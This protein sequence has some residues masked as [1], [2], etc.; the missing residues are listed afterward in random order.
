MPGGDR[1]GPLGDGPMTGKRM[2]YCVSIENITFPIGYGRGMR[3]RNRFSGSRG[4]GFG[5]RGG[6]GFQQ[7][8]IEDEKSAIE[9]EMKVLKEQLSYLEKRME[10]IGKDR[11]EP[12]D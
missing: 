9:N 6:F 4:S 3:R 2:G 7:K 12:T 11:E 8:N 1:T 10:E 5:F